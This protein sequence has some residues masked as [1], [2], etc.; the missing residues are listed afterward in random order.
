MV[1]PVQVLR[2]FRFLAGA[3]GYWTLFTASMILLAAAVLLP[4]WQAHEQLVAQRE[5]LA[6]HVADLRAEVE[7]IERA[8]RLMA[9]DAGI[10]ERLARMQL[11]YHRPGEVEV[12]VPSPLSSQA[13]ESPPRPIVAGVG[14][15]CDQ[16][17]A[18][19]MATAARPRSRA[20][21]LMIAAAL[22]LASV[23]IGIPTAGSRS[24]AEKNKTFANRANPHPAT[25]PPAAGSV[26]D[27]LPS[28]ARCP[29]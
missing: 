20:L 6:C 3:L 18:A 24:R 9:T 12:W 10:N 27:A 22:L 28:G 25:L 8:G 5:Q 21:M 17:L 4:E 14:P 19:L 13:P 29:P 26:R 2:A 23:V 7:R 16:A 11:G 15:P 1:N